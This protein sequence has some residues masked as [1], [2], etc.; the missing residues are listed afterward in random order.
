MDIGSV[1]LNF[2]AYTKIPRRTEGFSPSKNPDSSKGIGV[3]ILDPSP[4]ESKTWEKEVKTAVGTAA[5]SLV[6]PP[7]CE[8]FQVHGSKFKPNPIRNLG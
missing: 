4:I 5:S 7:Y 6:P 1:G 2:I 8:L 3:K